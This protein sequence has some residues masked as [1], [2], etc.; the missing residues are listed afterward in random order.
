MVVERMEPR[1]GDR[2]KPPRPTFRILNV[3]AI[4]PGN[5][6]REAPSFVLI[7]RA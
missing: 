2:R 6:R 7:T 5:D 3:G 4:P 1:Y